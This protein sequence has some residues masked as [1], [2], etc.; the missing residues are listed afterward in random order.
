MQLH[1]DALVLGGSSSRQPDSTHL[2]SAWYLPGGYDV[3]HATS[4]AF[5]FPDKESA[6]KLAAD[7][8]APPEMAHAVS[9]ELFDRLVTVQ[10]K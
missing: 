6:D 7:Y 5:Y 9:L 8:Q 4:V 2:V 1:Q 3:V 10:P